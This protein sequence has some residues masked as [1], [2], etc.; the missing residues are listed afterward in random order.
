MRTAK[1]RH[2]KC[3]GFLALVAALLARARASG[4][5][6][7]RRERL[8]PAEREA[9]PV[10]RGGTTIRSAV[11]GL[12]AGPTHPGTGPRHDDRRPRLDAAALRHRSSSASSPSTSA[13]ASPPGVTSRALQERV[14]QLVRTLRG[15]SGVR[16]VKR[17]RR[18]RDACRPLPGLRPPP[19]D[20]DARRPATARAGDDPLRAAGARRPRLHGPSPGSRARWTCRRRLPCSASR[21]GSGC[22]ATARSARR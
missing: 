14:G 19:P 1:E 9:G 18:R 11:E 7:G 17:A 8:V 20:H 15:I 10:A 5:R 3:S 6:R 16:G 22:R 4:G 2:V 13:G 12:L 21:S